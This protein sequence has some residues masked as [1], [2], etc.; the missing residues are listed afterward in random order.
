MSLTT[1]S[2]ILLASERDAVLTLTLNRPEVLNGLTRE[3]L[4][5][6]T[7]AV[8]EA[9]GDAKVRA[10]V[11][12][13]A[14]R[15][16]CSGADLRAGFAEDALD[17]GAYLDAHY[18]PLIR[19][20]RSVEK[21]VIA[22]VNGVAAGAGLS[23]A[24]ACDLRIAAESASFIQAFVRIGLV[25]DAGGSYFLPRLVGPSK[26]LEMS[27]LGDPVDAAEALRNGLVTRVVPDEQLA[28]ATAEYAGRLAR[29]PRSVG[30]V[31]TLLGGSLDHTLDEQLARE[32]AAQTLASGTDDFREGVTAF[33]EKR[34]AEF[35]GS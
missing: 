19:A 15:A 14:G 23:L 8:T 5:A 22:A 30:L 20:L 16:F 2:D 12:T 6:L 35:T 17:V 1:R 32:A 4:D 21:P 34:R 26:A 3:L 24:L 29:G 27:M 31:K 9:A 11:I 18:H 13:G 25:P 7:A 28:T 10:L 33:I